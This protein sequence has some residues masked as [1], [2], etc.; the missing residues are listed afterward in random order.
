VLVSETMLQ[1]TRVSRVVPKYL[2]FL[3]RFPDPA[4][5]AAAPLA[6]LLGLWTGLGYNRRAVHLHQAAGAI[7]TR[8]RGRLPGELGALLALPG[9]GPYTARAVLAF[10]F[11]HRVG[12]LDTNAARVLAR[13]VA[14]RRLGRAEAQRLADGLVPEGKAWA[15]N[16]A[17]LDLGATVCLARRPVCGHCPLVRSCAWARSGHTLPDPAEGTAGVSGRQ[18]PF[19]GSDRQG[20]GRLVAGLVS[21]PVAAADIASTAGWPAD[22][23]RA[24]RVARGLVADGLAAWGP[25]GRLVLP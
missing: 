10:A 22:P 1:Q 6:E 4:S 5:A 7:V 23:G 12:V 14:G 19:A 8:H 16:Q 18:S 11:E 17:V 9:V 20:R 21:G 25:D 15:Y 24:E 13:A 2:A 3:G